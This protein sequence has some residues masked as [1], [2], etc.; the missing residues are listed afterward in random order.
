MEQRDQQTH[1]RASAAIA[2]AGTK[3]AGVVPAE[4]GCASQGRKIHKCAKYRTC[5]EC[6]TGAA[7]RYGSASE[8]APATG[9]AKAAANASGKTDR[10]ATAAGSDATKPSP[11]INAPPPRLVQAF[12]NYLAGRYRGSD[13]HRSGNVSAVPRASFTRICCVQQRASPW[14]T[15]DGNKTQLD[16]A[17]ADARAAHALDA[18]RRA[19]CGDVL[20]AIPRVLRG[21]TLSVGSPAA[22]CAARCACII[23]GMLRIY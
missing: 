4:G 16:D 10:S 8:R 22:N 5:R 6:R 12:D 11:D 20:A 18:A 3:P 19:R 14:P 9:T 21:G 23:A 17:R 7:H 1:A 13:A 2:Q 15:I